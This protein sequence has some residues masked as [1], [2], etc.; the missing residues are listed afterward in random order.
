MRNSQGCLTECISDSHLLN[1]AL[2]S[3]S[4]VDL[5]QSNVIIGGGG[6]FSKGQK[7]IRIGVRRPAREHY[8]WGSACILRASDKI[9][10]C[11]M[12]AKAPA[13]SL[14]RSERADFVAKSAELFG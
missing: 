1:A 4:F 14:S 3:Q 2:K 8:D 7:L 12:I 6:V 11:L 5:A 10:R 9:N 13:C